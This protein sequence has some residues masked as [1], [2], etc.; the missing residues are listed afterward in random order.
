MILQ[1]FLTFIPCLYRC[2][3]VILDS[4]ESDNEEEESAQVTGK[5]LLSSSEELNCWPESD[6]KPGIPKSKSSFLFS[7]ITN[8]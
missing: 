5:E 6:G 7:I 8:M 2:S 3:G 4:D 1:I